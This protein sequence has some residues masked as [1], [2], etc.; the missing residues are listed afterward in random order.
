MAELYAEKNR[1]VR[2]R[3]LAAISG[4]GLVIGRTDA[5]EAD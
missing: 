1:W 4:K 3:L 5:A 2:D